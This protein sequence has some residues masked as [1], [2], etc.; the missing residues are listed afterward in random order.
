MAMNAM[1]NGLYLGKRRAK[2]D[3]LKLLLLYYAILNIIIASDSIFKYW[4]SFDRN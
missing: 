1:T 4:F 2:I 3:G